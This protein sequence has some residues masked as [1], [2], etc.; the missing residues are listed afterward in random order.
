LAYELAAL[1]VARASAELSDVRAVYVAGSV[2]WP[3]RL[4]AGHSDIDLTLICD[5]ATCERQI[6]LRRIVRR[7]RRVLNR[8][9]NLFYTLDL[10]PARDLEFMRA[11]GGQWEIEL[12]RFGVC[13]AGDPRWDEPVKRPE[14]ELRVEALTFCLRRWM[15]A[16]S[17]LLEGGLRTKDFGFHALELLADC[18]ACWLD[19]RRPSALDAVFDRARAAISAAGM[20]ALA[21][22][23]VASRPAAL[24][25]RLLEACLEVLDAFARDVCASWRETWPMVETAAPPETSPELLRLSKAFEREGFGRVSL[26]QR[27]P[28]S[29]DRLPVAV[30]EGQSASEVIGAARRVLAAK[31]DAH[32]RLRRTSRRPI[33]LTPALWHARALLS[34]APFRGALAGGNLPAP[35]A[36]LRL[37][38]LRARAAESFATLRAH[39]LRGGSRDQVER[40]FSADFHCFLPCIERSLSSG[41]LDL[42]CRHDVPLPTVSE[43]ELVP[44]AEEWFREL[45]DALDPHLRARLGG[46]TT[47]PD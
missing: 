23:L 7:S 1:A 9:G 11:F 20:P 34:P 27:F 39:G 13:I 21:T 15:N 26:L 31:P 28:H 12:D 5:P 32:E 43:A 4:S 24:G 3:E 44:T 42:G 22:V 47:A 29:G 8:F 14:S 16:G 17:R 2:A 46:H 19:M 30:F 45:R 18:L 40:A 35:P 33:F 6:E 10:V 25:L 38:I 37:A 36:D 41:V